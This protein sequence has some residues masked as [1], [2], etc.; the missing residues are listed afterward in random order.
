M[1]KKNTPEKKGKLIE[2]F[3]GDTPDSRARELS[4][5]FKAYGRLSFK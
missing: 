3:F 4:R 1:A 5:R 2:K